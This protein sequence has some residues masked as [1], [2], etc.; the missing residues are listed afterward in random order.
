MKKITMFI[1]GLLVI[2]MLAA[3]AAPEATPTVTEP[4]KVEEEEE[5]IAEEEEEKV[6]LEPIT[7]G[8]L[9][10]ISGPTSVL[11]NQVAK[12]FTYAIEKINEEGGMGGHPV[13]LITYDYKGE[14]QEA[15]NAYNRLVSEGAVVVMGPPVSNV[16][17]ALTPITYETKVPILSLANA[18]FLY[19]DESGNTTL[20]TF[21]CQI[22]AGDYAYTMASYAIHELGMKKF[23]LIYDETNSYSLAHIEPFKR[24]VA[25]Y[26]GEVVAEETFIK[27]DVDYKA[28]FEKVMVAEPDAIF[29]PNYTQNNVIAVQN[30]AQLGLDIP[31]LGALDHCHPFA[32]I[33][34]DPELADNIYVADNISYSDPRLD[35]LKI[36]YKEEIGE[37]PTNKGYIGWDAAHIL[38]WV[39]ENTGATD[40]AGFTE[41]LAQVKNLELLTGTF[42]MNPETHMPEGLPMV[43][44]KIEKGVYVELG[45]Y[46]YEPIE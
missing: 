45:P 2:S 21:L 27:G 41:G 31:I 25:A 7:I 26:D 23:G 30:R 11:G 19:K 9:Q 5:P 13:N 22:N 8:L 33:V 17:Q 20:Y 37:E 15:V 38:K 24:Y 10:D 35:E 3:C 4:E 1:V 39:V 46:N 42:N 28:Q 40:A 12:G 43:M 18:P 36:P 29:M 14:I 6:P 32:T 16:L 34:G 44:Y